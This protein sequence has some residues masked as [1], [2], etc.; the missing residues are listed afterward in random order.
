[1]SIPQ[2]TL[3][4]G[5]QP[6]LLAGIQDLI[7]RD[8]TAYLKIDNYGVLNMLNSQTKS[9]YQTL[10]RPGSEGQVDVVQMKY[11]Q[12]AIEADVM[13]TDNCTQTNQQLWREASVTT[14]MFSAYALYLEDE[15]I[16]H[17]QNDAAQ[18]MTAGTPAT[19][20]ISEFW[21]EVTAACNAIYAQMNR[22]LSTKLYANIGVNRVTGN[23]AA[24]SVNIAQ[25]TTNLPL[26]NGITK[27]QT[28]Y[29]NNL[30]YG[31]PWV[32]GSGNIQ[33]YFKQ[34]VAKATAQNG[35]NTRI[36]S[37]D[38]DFYFDI[39][40]SSLLGANQCIVGAPDS[41]K[42]VESFKYKGFRA[43]QRGTSYFGTI[44]L[45]YQ[46]TPNTVAM[47]EFDFQAKFYDCPSN[48]FTDY[49]YGTPITVNRGWNLIISKS[50]DL[51]Q[52]PSDSY[53]AA[54]PMFG[55]NGTLRYTITNT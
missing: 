37:Q 18:M 53:V 19:P 15:K 43:G 14:S 35:L 30:M 54:D 24:Q 49:Y 20:V 9:R 10:N 28:D 39:Q 50:Y 22:N 7:G 51:F 46:A 5:W 4:Q 11:L 55:N 32:V 44:M 6:Y 29:Q 36:E 38:M 45:P 17:Y 25:D 2:M 8:N 34:Q 40:S 27:I 47:M 31:R 16:T 41:C 21:M 52:V 13:N 33:G 26:N 42:L 1:M 48:S 12:P 23:N 3:G